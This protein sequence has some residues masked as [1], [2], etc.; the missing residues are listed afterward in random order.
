M[1]VLLVHGLGRTPV[2][3]FGLALRLR[4]AGHQ[5]SFFG[6]MPA[7]ESWDDVIGRLRGRLERLL[8]ARTDCAVVGHSLGGILLATAL[9]EWPRDRQFPMRLVTLG[10]PTRVPRIARVA[11]RVRAFRLL[12]GQAAAKLVDDRTFLVLETLPCPWTAISG[13]RG[14][15]GTWSPFAGETNDGVLS[16][17]EVWSPTSTARHE[18]RATHTF[19]MNCSAVRRIVMESLVDRAHLT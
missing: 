4:L 11:A 10:T 19:M 1:R 18:V 7:L 15:L 8:Q 16:L 14:W 3:L 9:Q 5:P 6:Y 2:S 13:S 17:N 12:A